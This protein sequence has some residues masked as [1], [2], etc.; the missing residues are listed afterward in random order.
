MD[1][2]SRSEDLVRRLRRRLWA[3]RMV[4]MLLLAA[5]L[6]LHFGQFGEPSACLVAVDGRPAVVM[7][8]RRD[9]ER[10][11][12]AI[13]DSS[14][15]PGKVA[16]TGKVTLHTVPEANHK[17]L[18]DAAAMEVLASKLHPVVQAAAILVNGEVVAGLPDRDEA[19]RAISLLL[20][21]FSPP[22][23]DVARAF[24]ESVKIETRDVSADRYVPSAAAAVERI[25]K[26]AAPR[27]THEVRPGQVAWKIALDYQVSLSR[28][29]AANPGVNLNT[30]HAGD[31]LQIPGEL[32]PLTVVARREVQ[33]DLGGGRTQTVRIT[34]ENGVEVSRDVI[35]RHRPAGRDAGPRQ[36]RRHREEVVL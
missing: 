27:G 15:L 23:E 2:L 11:L 35:G 3:E 17:V 29:Q 10:V 13:K 19:V 16:F 8:S 25:A 26:A 28:L 4:F 1:D 34:Y 33:E 36:R 30:I 5:A 18:S 20:L 21:H 7:R 24:R 31:Q 9:A 32:P 14:G 22:G 6:A 12:K